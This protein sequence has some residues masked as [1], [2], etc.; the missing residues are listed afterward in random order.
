M[1]EFK[2]SYQVNDE[3]F[4]QAKRIL[5]LKLNRKGL[6]KK[7]QLG[8]VKYHKDGNMT[9]VSVLTDLGEFI[10]WAKFNPNDVKRLKQTSK[11]GKWYTRTESKFNEKSGRLRALNRALD[12]VIEA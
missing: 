7:I 8:S 1:N 12:R 6:D 4:E 11:K 2:L 10:G 5:G 9:I 3:D